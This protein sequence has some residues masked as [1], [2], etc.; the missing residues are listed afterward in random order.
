M[1]KQ[2]ELH[3]ELAG[4]IVASIVKPPLET[5]GDMTDVL[6]LL[7]SVIMGVML[8]TAKLGGDEILLDVVVERVKARL[9]EKRLG[10]IETAGRA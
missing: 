8:M 3:N 9:A 2:A 6:I 10:G 5:G 7:E 1:S 4:Q